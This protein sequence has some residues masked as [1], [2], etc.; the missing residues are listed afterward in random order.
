MRFVVFG[1]GAIGG[2]TGARLA[3]HGHDVVLI[4]RGAHLERLRADGITV[5]SADDRTQVKVPAFGSPSELTFGDG[6]V[7]LLAVKSQATK[8]ALESLRAVA[9][10]AT[11][12]ACLQNGVE[13]ERV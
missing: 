5:E 12:V 7:V 2:V 9:P 11:P 13:N 10:S 3:Q 8:D 4:A 1:A 6:D